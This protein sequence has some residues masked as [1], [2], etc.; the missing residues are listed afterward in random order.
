MIANAQNR[1]VDDFDCLMLDL[2]GVCYLGAQPVKNAIETLNC[3][4][5]EN[6][7]LL[8]ITNNSSRVPD[9]V[10]AQLTSLG[11]STNDEQVLTSAQATARRVR[12]HFPSSSKILALGGEGVFTALRNEGFDV[13]KSADDD[14]VAVVQGWA[15][16]IG[17]AQLSEAVLAI[18]KG[19]Q[20]FATNLDA[21]L[22]TERG[23][24][25][26]NGSFVAAVRNATGAPVI[27][28]GKPEAF[29]YQAAQQM[30]MAENPLAIG[31]RLDTDIRGANAS[32]IPSMHV[33]TGVNDARE[34]M[35]APPA[36]RPK[37]LAVDLRDLL[38]PYPQVKTEVDA[39]TG[40]G[41]ARCL[42]STVEISKHELRVD[43][44]VC[45]GVAE[46]SEVAITVNAYRALAHLLWQIADCTSERAALPVLPKFVVTN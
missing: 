27:S 17:W 10:A 31:D 20:H 14:P 28:S 5:A 19:A 24:T 44:V 23:E 42:D 1:L 35:L 13:V 29:I 26:G 41:Q 21:T 32:S 33:L 36:E 4:R 40:E 25:I 43:G 6:K 18:K 22:P 39:H 9:S 3:M 45:S 46:E 16:S 38:V 15:N 11:L 2:D 34:V 8:Y 12:E 7:Q 30:C 37:Y